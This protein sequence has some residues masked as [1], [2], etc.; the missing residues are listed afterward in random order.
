MVS[1]IV[2]NLISTNHATPSD[3]HEIYFQASI[4]IQRIVLQ[5]MRYFYT[6]PVVW[7][8]NSMI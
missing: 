5:I 3:S 7:K 2:Y 6:I 4:K 8:P 1:K